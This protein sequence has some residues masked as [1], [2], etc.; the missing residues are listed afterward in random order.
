MIGAIIKNK[1][2]SYEYINILNNK[3]S[4]IH[5]DNNGVSKSNKKY[6]DTFFKNL[7]FN[8]N[9]VY[10]KKYKNYDVYYDK[11]NNLKHFMK[12]GIEDIELFY[13]F[14]G[15]E[16]TLYNSKEPNNSIRKQKRKENIQK[17]FTTA[18]I[19]IQ[20]LVLSKD[21]LSI[22]YLEAYKTNI[23]R[24]DYK[25]EDAVGYIYDPLEIDYYKYIYGKMTY[26]DAIN[27][28]YNSDNLTEE[29]KDFLANEELLQDVF[30]Y[31]NE[32]SL[33]YVSNLNF[34]DISIVY[35]EL[36]EDK[37]GY[38]SCKEPNIIHISKILEGKLDENEYTKGVI[39]H[40]FIHLLQ[41][42]VCPYTYIAESSA[43]L[44]AH[45]YFDVPVTAYPKGVKNLQLLIDIIGPE[46]IMKMLFT[47]DDNT[48]N[49][50][51]KNNLSNEEY[52]NL[53]TYFQDSSIIDNS[54]IANDEIKRLLCT[55][56][57]NIYKKDIIEDQNILYSIYYD[58]DYYIE[59]ND[60]YYLNIRK[61]EETSGIRNKFNDQYER[62]ISQTYDKSNSKKHI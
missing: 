13:K 57:K 55:L 49:N 7:F 53:I 11:T 31:Y 51:L 37:G 1:D 62:M 60:K 23:E 54:K 12:K 9:C 43:E 20:I 16:K 26:Q 48:F 8:D 47:G 38:Y 2:N 61:I 10:I 44:L 22:A 35:E 28:I 14:N 58:N 39:G 41:V 24:N 19:G 3:L 52:E 18:F 15:I 17:I 25:L 21:V 59:D 40:E 29:Q 36:D 46:P 5:I 33:E 6:I 50:I 32:T 56:Y 4:F 30:S 45:E 42:P 34:K 27:Y